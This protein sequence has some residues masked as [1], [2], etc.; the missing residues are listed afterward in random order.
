VEL[1]PRLIVDGLN[2]L[3]SRPDGWWRDRPAAMRRLVGR[4]DRLAESERIAIEVVFDGREHPAVAAAAERVA[5]GF[6]PGGPNAADREIAA[7]ARAAER[8]GDLLVVS[9]DR[10]LQAA[11]KAA[12]AVGIGSGEFARR[13][14][15]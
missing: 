8:P 14:L 4:L 7:R 3:G 11:V 13:W 15:D 2:L 5:V 6:A 9:S 1:R 10:R 12:G